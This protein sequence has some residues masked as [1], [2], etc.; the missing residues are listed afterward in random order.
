MQIKS[1]YNIILAIIFYY[2]NARIES[3]VEQYSMYMKKY[4]IDWKKIIEAL[5]YY[6]ILY[7]RACKEHKLSSVPIT[8]HS[9]EAESKEKHGVRDSMPELTL[10]LMFIVQSR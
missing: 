6:M 2:I 1:K 9:T 3:T 10:S 7:V 8:R 5:M 4:I